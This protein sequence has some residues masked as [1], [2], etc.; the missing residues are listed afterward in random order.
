VV[1][2][3]D[4]SRRLRGA[5]VTGARDAANRAAEFTLA[6]T[7]PAALALIVIPG[8]IVAVLFE[9]GA[10][11]AADTR[12]PALAVAI[13]GAGL[14]AVVLQKVL[15]PIYY[16]RE[17]ARTP[18]RYTVHS[19]LRNALIA[20]GLAPLIGFSAAAW[21]TTLAGWAM[22][23]QLWWGTR[24]MGEAAA[25]DARLRHAAP[26]ILAACVVMG[27]ALLAGHHVL[28]ATLER[29]FF[30]YGA[31]ASLVLLGMAVYALA[32]VGLGGLRLGDVR[33]AMRRGRA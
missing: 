21:G 17:D 20:I 6:L 28:R 29:D 11:D 19:M 13:Y 12:A 22:V 9:R 14:P 23:L 26:R 32:V 24:A 30:R 27:A 8:P 4:L 18:L 33:A 10:F 2:L 1:L 3:P 25:V 16:A 5:D 7:L 15:L 31:L